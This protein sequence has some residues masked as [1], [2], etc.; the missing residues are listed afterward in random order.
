AWAS[1]PMAA[2]MPLLPPQEPAD[3]LA[4]GPFAFADQ[5]RVESIVDN[6]GFKHIHIEKF[7]G[8]MDM[9]ATIADAVDQSLSIGPLARAAAE[10][11]EAVRA[12]LR[13]AVAKALEPYKTAKGVFPPAACWFVRARND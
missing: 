1:V 5:A 10:L 8:H 11:D 6:A 4:P 2:A 7:D 3:P 9:G 12:K 13:D